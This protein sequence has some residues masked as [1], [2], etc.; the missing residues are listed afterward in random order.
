VKLLA[1]S[2]VENALVGGE[3]GQPPSR[4]VEAT[5]LAFKQKLTVV[6]HTHDLRGS[7]DGHADG[8]GASI[9]SEKKELLR[10]DYARAMSDQMGDQMYEKRCNRGKR[11]YEAVLEG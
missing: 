8:T 1:G 7:F 9:S 2:G 5:L 10:R 3:G 11:A 4:P 6:Q